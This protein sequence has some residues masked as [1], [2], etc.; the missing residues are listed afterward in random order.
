MWTASPPSHHWGRCCLLWVSPRP[1][2]PL[3]L[4][5]HC[6][7]RSPHPFPQWSPAEAQAQFTS[8]SWMESSKL[9]RILFTL[10]HPM[11]MDA[12]GLM[13]FT[14]QAF[15][16]GGRGRTAPADKPLCPH[17]GRGAAS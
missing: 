4:L 9:S 7:L 11:L 6:R 12:A 3:P 2:L 16:R 5:S 14:L 13:L 15:T 17:Q 10:L 8:V 1:S